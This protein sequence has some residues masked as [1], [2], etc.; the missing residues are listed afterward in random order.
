MTGPADIVKA[1]VIGLVGMF[2]KGEADPLSACKTYLNRIGAY[3]DAL[4]AYVHVCADVALKDAEASAARWRA[5]A[6]LSP[7]D[8]VPVAV[9]ANI[10]VKGA[11]WH[12]GIA[13]YKDRNADLDAECVARLRAGGAV[14]LGVLNMH[15][16]ALGATTDNP[17]FGRCHNPHRTGVTPG[18][19]SG[20]SGAAVAAGLCAAALGTDTMGSVRIPSAYC[21]V[22][23]HKP[24]SALVSTEGVID[25]SWTL[26]HVGPHARSVEDIGVMLTVLSALDDGADYAAEA[27]RFAASDL[28]GV[29]I[30]KLSFAGAVK[31]MPE[32][33][34]AFDAAAE[35]FEAAG[36]DLIDV[37]LQNYDYGR[38]RRRG[39]L[40]SEAE[41]AVAHSEALERMPD[42]F[43]D[44]FRGYLEWGANK[45]AKDLA[46]A[47]DAVRGVDLIAATAFSACDVLIAPTAPQTAFAFDA[48]VPENQA[49]FTAFANFAGLPATAV[50]A[51]FSADGLPLSVQVIAP[52]L[53]DGLALAVAGAYAAAARHD[54]RPQ[55][56]GF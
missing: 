23:G 11:P 40:I 53:Q 4:G 34:K 29:R 35:V 31:V 51:G 21:G 2:A 44:S 48:P 28:S 37:S 3:N 18:G 5:G 42:G 14:I 26:D 17:W 24:D 10:A 20:G 16:G 36:A 13:A 8:G 56:F 6:P 43:S 32:V 52:A 38:L 12:A 19:S 55:G 1:G 46:A 15:E 7:L 54:M 22:V 33:A 45:S 41:G 30:G 25:L 49:D 39:L 9:K 47:Y 50:P 27:R